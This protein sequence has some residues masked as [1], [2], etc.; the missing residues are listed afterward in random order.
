MIKRYNAK[1][2]QGKTGLSYNDSYNLLKVHE[3]NLA[4]TLNSVEYF[5]KYIF[6][7]APANELINEKL[8]VANVYRKLKNILCESFDKS[9][10]N[11]TNNSFDSI[12]TKYNSL[13][14]ISKS[15]N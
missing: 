10:E 9:N 7:K 14:I 4:S 12:N 3:Y 6:N 15:K 1:I 2:V 5:S 11:T 13:A 8:I